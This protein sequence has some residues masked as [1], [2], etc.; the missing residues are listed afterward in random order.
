MKNVHLLQLYSYTFAGEITWEDREA[1]VSHE[2]LER[3]AIF[4][5]ATGCEFG[6]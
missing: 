2:S 4:S 1:S 5:K 6:S 3:L